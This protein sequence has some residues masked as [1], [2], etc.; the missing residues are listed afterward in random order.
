MRE[1]H[2]YHGVIIISIIIIRLVVGNAFL[3]IKCLAASKDLH[4]PLGLYRPYRIHTLRSSALRFD[5]ISVLLFK[6]D[7]L[8][9]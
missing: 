3:K 9:S 6:D 5:L 8:G 7:N 4:H 2:D 1:W